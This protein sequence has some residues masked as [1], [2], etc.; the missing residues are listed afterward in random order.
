[1]VFR[2]GRAKWRRGRA[3]TVSI[4]WIEI[5]A[6]GTYFISFGNLGFIPDFKGIA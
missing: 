6:M 2:L 4:T 3:L 1:V 5:L